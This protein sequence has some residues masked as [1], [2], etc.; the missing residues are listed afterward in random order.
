MRR[1]ASTGKLHAWIANA[2]SGSAAGSAA[3]D[4]G[5]SCRA[6]GTVKVPV[7]RPPCAG[8]R[9]GAAAVHHRAAA[10]EIEDQPAALHRDWRPGSGVTP[11]IMVMMP[12][13]EV[14]DG[15][16]AAR[17]LGR[18]AQGDAAARVEPLDLD[19]AAASA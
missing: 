17:G 10:V 19:A 8:R 2:A 12:P 13:V 7:T 5:F 1:D 3:P 4:A 14:V 11:P 15:E 18:A 16:V 9:A 6:A